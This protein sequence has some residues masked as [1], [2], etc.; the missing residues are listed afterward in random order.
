MSKKSTSALEL[1]NVTKKFGTKIALDGVS[2]RVHHNEV[3]GLIGE[4]GAGKST[5][6]KLL[7]G[8]HSQDSGT[9]TIHGKPA[10][11]RS[12]ADAAA[13]GIGVVHQE[14]SLITNLTIAD[15]V[16]IG[17]P[18][19]T[20]T[21]AGRLGLYPWRRLHAEAAELLGR[22]GI[23]L[24]PRTKVERLSF[25]ER[26]MV[27]IA[28]A[29]GAG[30]HAGQSPIIILDEPTSVLEAKE[31]ET[32]QHEIDKLR[33][34]GSVILVSHRLQE[35]LDF[36]DRIYV[37][38]DGMVVAER[39]SS[40]THPDEL[41]E[42]MTGRVAAAAR[43]PARSFEGTAPVLELRDVVSDG[44][45]SVSLS[46][47][48]GQIHC[49]VG[50]TSSGAEQLARLPF[51]LLPLSAGQMLVDGSAVTS[52][53]PR[54]AIAAGMAYLPSERR[55]EGVVEGLTLEENLT[56]AHPLRRA[57]GVLD[58]KGRRTLTNDWISRLDVRPPSA[59]ADI[60]ELSG[61]NQQKIALAK[62]LCA[63]DLR[64]LVLDHPMRGLDPGA[65]EH[66]KTAIRKAAQ[67]KVAVLMV[68]DTLEEALEIADVITVMKDG[69][70]N[71]RFDLST[72]EPTL[73]DLLEKLV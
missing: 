70:V 45:H 26:Q 59:I 23:D 38:R 5:L 29:V 57:P 9:V 55:L 31:I 2:L 28:K 8:L 51:G 71:A 42:L 60:A 72:Q 36:T 65:I 62:W 67:Q 15:N 41:F 33:S 39:V 48:A 61:G 24:D 30:S 69:K 16:T 52:R 35:V 25:A 14:Q 73:N 17:G 21:K 43:P 1:D 32:L 54:E 46:T 3:V 22:I 7:A 47:H 37:L 18:T 50:S 44:V 68:A 49:V 12:A 58:L 4:N 63:T 20:S 34:L 13:M 66:V 53:R 10:Q 56:L 40:E 19:R 64:I 6:L 27:E 11:L